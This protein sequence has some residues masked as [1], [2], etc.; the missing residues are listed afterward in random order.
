PWSGRQAE[1]PRPCGDPVADG[2]VTLAARRDRAYDDVAHL[3]TRTGQRQARK[4][5]GA[6]EAVE[7]RLE[8]VDLA[9][10]DRRGLEHPVATV[11]NVIVE[12]QHHEGRIG[13]DAAKL[14]RVEG[15]VADGLAR[16]ER[17]KMSDDLLDLEHAGRGGHWHGEPPLSRGRA[18]RGPPRRSRCPHRRG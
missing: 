16:A 15:P 17:A 1:A 4:G 7:V 12:G 14:A 2:A 10:H 5:R 13:H 11:D 8:I 3:R 18:P 6:E 9:L